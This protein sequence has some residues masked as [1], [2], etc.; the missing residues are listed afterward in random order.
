M[1]S[2]ITP[3]AIDSPGFTELLLF[4]IRQ[5]KQIAMEQWLLPYIARIDSS[6][7]GD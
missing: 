7:T 3:I 2:F 1:P 4:D 6:I 5:E